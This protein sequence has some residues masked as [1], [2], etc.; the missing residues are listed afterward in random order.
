MKQPTLPPTQKRRHLAFAKQT[1]TVKRTDGQLK[2]A[3]LRRRIEDL[4]DQSRLREELV[5]TWDAV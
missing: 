1:A 2:T 3:G 4:I 5:E